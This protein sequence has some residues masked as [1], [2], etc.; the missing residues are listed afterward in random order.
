MRKSSPWSLDLPAT[1]SPTIDR[2]TSPSNLLLQ[3]GNSSSTKSLLDR[4]SPTPL[5]T[6]LSAPVQFERTQ[7][8]VEAGGAVGSAFVSTAN[9]IKSRTD[10]SLHRRVPRP[11]PFDFGL[12]TVGVDRC[13]RRDRTSTS[14]TYTGELVRSASFNGTASKPRPTPPP[15]PPPEVV[16]LLATYSGYQHHPP[17][18]LSDDVTF[19][20]ITQPLRKKYYSDIASISQCGG[21]GGGNSG[22]SSS[23]A[24]S[25]GRSPSERIISRLKP[26][27]I[28]AC[29]VTSLNIPLARLVVP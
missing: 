20:A 3:T 29:K 21:G 7:S 28:K 12:L 22:S 24:W 15:P 1:H 9:L 19:S 8:C 17:P 14:T 18:P 6:K 25:G 10:P 4:S 2:S 16:A 26:Q 13:D 23:M 11:E 27:D 5:G